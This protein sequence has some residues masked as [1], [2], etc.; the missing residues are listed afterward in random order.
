MPLPLDFWRNST[1]VVLTAT[2]ATNAPAIL[3]MAGSASPAP[4][5][6]KWIVSSTSAAKAVFDG[7][8]PA[9]F[10]PTPPTEASVSLDYDLHLLVP[11]RVVEAT[12][13]EAAHTLSCTFSWGTP[14]VQGRALTAITTAYPTFVSS[15]TTDATGALGFGILDFDIGAE[16]AAEIVAATITGTPPYV[17]P[18]DW[19]E[20]VLN[21]VTTLNASAYL[22]MLSPSLIYRATSGLWY[23]NTGTAGVNLGTN[24]RTVRGGGGA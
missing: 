18:R 6:M 14:G 9:D 8:I 22:E 23:S 1:G 3:P 17:T 24:F 4:L 20:I 15:N 13:L 12:A 11:I 10:N 19:F 7:R 5:V 2:G 21:P 16:I